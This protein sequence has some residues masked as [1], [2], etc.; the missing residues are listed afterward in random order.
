[1]KQLNE[2]LKV[3]REKKIVHHNIKL[4]SIF[5]QLNTNS[6]IEN[7]FEIK[8]GDYSEAKLLTNDS[9]EWENIKPYELSKKENYNE[10]DKRDLLYIGKEIYRMYFNDKNKINIEDF[11]DD[12]LKDLLN[13]L[14]E[15]DDKKRIE[16]NDYF[17][18][19][20]FNADNND[21]LIHN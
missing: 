15:D 2:V 21:N 11:K 1:M 18:H 14:L 8:L 3:L 20:F 9:K 4:E 5:V 7:E 6:T 16:W 10:L 19:A 12:E 17:N 13:R